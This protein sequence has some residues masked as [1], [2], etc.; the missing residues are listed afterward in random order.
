MRLV[1]LRA[2]AHDHRAAAAAAPISRNGLVNGPLRGETVILIHTAVYIAHSTPTGIRGY[3]ESGG[4]GGG[5]TRGDIH[6]ALRERDP[7]A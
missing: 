1:F 7:Q 4:G 5:D 2:R 6:G 3:A